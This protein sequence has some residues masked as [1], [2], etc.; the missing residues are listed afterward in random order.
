MGANGYGRLLGSLQNGMGKWAEG[1]TGAWRGYRYRA[2]DQL[3]KL[4]S[5]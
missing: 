2:W 4:G 3:L 5:R 1:T